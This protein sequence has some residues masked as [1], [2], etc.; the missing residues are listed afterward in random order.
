MVRM[1][2]TVMIIKIGLTQIKLLP[3]SIHKVPVSNLVRNT[4]Y[5][6][7]YVF[8][9][10]PPSDN[11]WNSTLKLDHSRFLSYPFIIIIIIIIIFSP[12]ALQHNSG[13]GRL[14][15]TFRFTSVI[16]SRTVSRTPWTRDQLVARPLPAHKH[17]KTH[18]QHKR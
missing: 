1:T 18:T 12:L 17:R 7:H 13:L 9:G 11:C 10:L 3:T 15:E 4:D 6:F 5:I 8:R 2:T 14:H 16:R